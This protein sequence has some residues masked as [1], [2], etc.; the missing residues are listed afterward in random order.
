MVKHLN[1]IEEQI[2]ESLAWKVESPLWDK[3]RENENKVPT[4][5]E[6][7]HETSSPFLPHLPVWQQ[8]AWASRQ[9]ASAQKELQGGFWLPPRRKSVRELGEAPFIA[10]LLLLLWPLLS[11]G[12]VAVG[13]APSRLF[14]G[15]HQMPQLCLC[16][17][18]GRELGVQGTG[19]VR[20]SESESQASPGSFGPSACSFLPCLPQ[21]F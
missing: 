9:R 1:H 4:C 17:L 20:N 10:A 21:P 6:V 16:H 13:Q 8:T 7:K 15:L 5:E 11:C 18:L 19:Q 3:I 12:L 14:Q 2:L